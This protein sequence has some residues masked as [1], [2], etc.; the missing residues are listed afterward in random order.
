MTGTGKDE[1]TLMLREWSDGDAGALDKILPLV[2][3]ELHRQASRYLKKER[4]NH[5]I[6][7]TELINE[8]Y[9]KL[10]GQHSVHWQ[11]RSHFFGIAAQAMRRILVDYARSTHRL[12]R[13]G[14]ELTIMLDDAVSAA[15]DERS[16]DLIALDEALDRLAERD[17]QQAR[18][19][20]LRYFSGLELEAVAQVLGV[21][22]TTVSREWRM[23]KAWLRRE[24]TR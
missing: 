21:S 15:T 5:T 12:K 1:I 13:G 6:Q 7:T 22:R 17:P 9:I 19:V 4:P 20:E 23:A 11:N 2:Y 3:D 24:L 16:I 18:V 8:A 14:N 10:A